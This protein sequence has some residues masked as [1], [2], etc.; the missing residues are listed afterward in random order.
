MDSQTK[1]LLH[2]LWTRA[3]GNP[4]YV[5]EDWMRLERHLE[6]LDRRHADRR[7]PTNDRR[8]TCV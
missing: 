2:T 6:R 3:V 7:K 8:Q 5:K 1:T 4:D